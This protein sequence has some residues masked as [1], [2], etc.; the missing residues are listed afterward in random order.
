MNIDRKLVFK[1]QTKNL[2]YILL[3]QNAPGSSSGGFNFSSGSVPSFDANAK[4]TFNFTG[5]AGLA[6][7]S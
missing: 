3:F 6:A 7:F 4:P 2:A 5:G 1:R